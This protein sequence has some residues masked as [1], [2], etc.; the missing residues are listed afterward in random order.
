[1]R[2]T[3]VWN[4]EKR[5]FDCNEDT[6]HGAL[7]KCGVLFMQPCGKGICKGCRASISREDG[8]FKTE[9]VCQSRFDCDMTIVLPQSGVKVDWDLKKDTDTE[10]NKNTSK[11]LNRKKSN[12]GL[13]VDIGTTTVGF[14]LCSSDDMGI[15]SFALSDNPQ[16]KYGWDVI[17]RILAAQDGDDKAMG[18]AITDCI[19][20]TIDMFC[21]SMGYDRNQFKRIVVAGNTTMTHLFLR[22]DVTGMGEYPFDPGNISY[23]V[24]K[25]NGIKTDI[26]P[27]VSAFVGG[28][29][30]SGMYAM[31]MDKD[32]KHT[33][34]L[35]DLGTN[36]EMV[37]GDG[38]HFLATAT[39][40]G[41]AFEAVG[42]SCGMPGITGAINDI[43]LTPFGSEGDRVTITRSVIR[44]GNGVMP[45]PRG[46]CG[47]GLIAT[48]SELVRLGLVN[49]DG[50][51][52]NDL[53][54]KKGF[55]VYYAGPYEKNL[56]L[57][58]DDVRQI[59]VAKAA[60]SAG[61]KVLLDK[62]M[63]ED[64]HKAPDRVYL[65]G[66]FGDG[67]DLEAAVRIGLIPPEWKDITK[68]VGNTS[69]WGTEKLLRA[70]LSG[71]EEEGNRVIWLAGSTKVINLAMEV[72]FDKQFVKE[73]H[74]E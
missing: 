43:K 55:T 66:G 5:D 2:L 35:I 60:V 54:R 71:D 30:V 41:P 17:T 74:Y 47:S 1:M 63:S 29:I 22:E 32:D 58:Q 25:F 20:D 9:L 46:I 36:G 45:P 51:F 19:D 59:L 68:P 10:E 34:L 53:L 27:C 61:I 57:S 56:V 16:I 42:I 13:A 3:I 40:A 23:R 50:T 12:L 72:E 38:M 33:N 64:G 65:A 21:S 4:N 44:D 67:I 28:D 24:A 39:A 26:F 48:V 14:A 31:N 62:W 70:L 73:M 11:D 52:T 15:A 18:D 6:L 49:K 7:Q 69:L 8:E 37:I